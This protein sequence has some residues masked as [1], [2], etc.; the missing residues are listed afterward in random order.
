MAF[1]HVVN[2]YW[3]TLVPQSALGLPDDRGLE[4]DLRLLTKAIDEVARELGGCHLNVAKRADVS[5]AT[6]TLKPLI[7]AVT[8]N[9]TT[10]LDLGGS[11]APV[12]KFL[13]DF[14][15]VSYSFRSPAMPTDSNL[16]DETDVVRYSI[17]HILSALPPWAHKR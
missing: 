3:R 1:E 11:M 9:L 4:S 10:V 17:L 7:T 8:T 13:V 5:R 16:R 12:E 14:I 15:F 6:N 2:S